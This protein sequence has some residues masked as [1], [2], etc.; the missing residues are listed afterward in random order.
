[1]DQSTIAFAPRSCTVSHSWLRA[2]SE[3]RRSIHADESP[4]TGWN[5]SASTRAA[6]GAPRM[7]GNKW[8]ANASTR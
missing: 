6:A 4:S 1:M 3:R 5:P 8:I 2:V 7:R